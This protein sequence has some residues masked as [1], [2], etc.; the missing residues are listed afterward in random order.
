MRAHAHGYSIAL[1]PPELTLAERADDGDAHRL[2]VI[3][4][5]QLDCA[6]IVGGL[7]VPTQL[8]YWEFCCA[9]PYVVRRGERNHPLV[10]RW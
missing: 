6:M 5:E 10:C 3:F 8:R 7:L 1:L 2:V 4:G 9:I